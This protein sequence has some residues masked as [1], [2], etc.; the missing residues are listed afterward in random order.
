MPPIQGKSDGYLLKK[1]LRYI[2]LMLMYGLVAIAAAIFCTV[3]AIFGHVGLYSVLSW[4]LILF[5]L[6]AFR[7]IEK[8][9]DN[10]SAGWDGELLALTE[11]GNNLP[12]HTFVIKDVK[13]P[14]LMGNIDAV[15]VAPGGV[16]T[17]EVKHIKKCS[18][19]LRDGKLTCNGFVME[20]DILGQAKRQAFALN[21]YLRQTINRDE[22]VTPTV[23]FS[24][25]LVFLRFGL[26][27]VKNVYVIRLPWVRKLYLENFPTKYEDRDVSEIYRAIKKTFSP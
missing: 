22:W 5:C 27:P 11:L 24:H 17:V 6:W 8:I 12:E 26:R 18:I 3:T 2:Y 23:I 13:L 1:E 15:V 16:F 21:E 14:N 19:G 4:L 7:K 25:P 10:Y 9:A 20:R